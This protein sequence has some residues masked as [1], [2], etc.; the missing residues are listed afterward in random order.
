MPAVALDTNGDYMYCLKLEREFVK[1]RRDV[2]TF[3][4]YG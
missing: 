1:L 2:K 4:G 3:N